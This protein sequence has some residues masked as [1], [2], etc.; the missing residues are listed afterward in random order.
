[1]P[2]DTKGRRPMKRIPAIADA[3][4]YVEMDPV[5]N[6]SVV[7]S[8]PSEHAGMTILGD[9]GGYASKEDATKV[10]KGLPEDKCKGIVG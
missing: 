1:M 3:R 8:Q 9:Q 7:D 10:L 5:G 2:A 4:Y 6:C